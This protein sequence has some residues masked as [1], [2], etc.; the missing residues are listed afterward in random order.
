VSIAVQHAD[1]GSLPASA[2]AQLPA[3]GDA[4]RTPSAYTA[5]IRRLAPGE[6]PW[7]VEAWMI[8]RHGTIDSLT[9]IEF[10]PA[11]KAAVARLRAEHEVAV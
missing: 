11:V 2:R 7:L 5:I 10:A 1:D 9:A 6:D 4:G 3:P 8:V